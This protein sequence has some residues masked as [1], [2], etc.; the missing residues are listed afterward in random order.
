MIMSGL[1]TLTTD[2]GT[3]D[4]YAG[5]I[6]GMVYTTNLNAKIIDITH[7]IPPHDVVSAAFTIVRAYEFFPTGTVHIAIVDP[8]VGSKRKNIAVKTDRYIF[9]GPDNGIF[10][11]VLGDDDAIEIREIVNPTFLQ[12]KISS[13]FH[14]RD[15]YAPC[16]GHLSAGRD[17]SEIGPVLNRLKKL[18][19]PQPE[20]NGNILKGEIVSIDSFGNLI[21]NISIHA[22]NTFAGKRKIEVSFAAE[23]FRKIMDHYSQ[24]QKGTP[25]VLFGASGYLEISMN[26][27][28]AASYFMTSIGSTV[29][30][31]RS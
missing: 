22:F 5:I 20:Q 29:T 18:V 12:D 21:S 4:P 30:V 3:K 13:T 2:F 15:I 28:N 23:R 10:S 11:L 27:G 19:Y 8:K 24:A 6:R 31:R 17:F 14:G 26:E 25:L 9:I 1:V 16:A 7:D